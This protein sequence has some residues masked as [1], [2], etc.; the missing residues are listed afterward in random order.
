MARFDVSDLPTDDYCWVH[1]GSSFVKSYNDGISAGAATSPVPCVVLMNSRPTQCSGVNYAAFGDDFDDSSFDTCRW[2]KTET[3]AGSVSE[4][5]SL[6]LATT[7]TGVA[8]EATISTDL[9]LSGDF[10]LEFAYSSLSY[11]LASSGYTMQLQLRLTIGGTLFETGMDDQTGGAGTIG[12]YV[13]DGTSSTYFQATVSTSGV[14]KV[15][16]VGTDL[17]FYFGGVLKQTETCTTAIPSMHF[18]NA[19]GGYR[20]LKIG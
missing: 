19:R 5:T 8:S 14:F 11:S 4:S 1:D 2:S 9:D 16:R 6:S 10:S 12:G 13:Y 18:E 3:G 7:S 15:A 17:K 20:G